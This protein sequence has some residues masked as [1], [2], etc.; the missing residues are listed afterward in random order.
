M[1]LEMPQDKTLANDAYSSFQK[2]Y[3]SLGKPQNMILAN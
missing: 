3:T 2:V 1:A